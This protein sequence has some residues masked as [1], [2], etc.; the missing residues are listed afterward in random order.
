M[1]LLLVLL[2]VAAASKPQCDDTTCMTRAF[3]SCGTGASNSACRARVLADCRAA[4]GVA[5]ATLDPSTWRPQSHR[6]CSVADCSAKSFF[7]CGMDASF[8]ACRERYSRR[9]RRACLSKPPVEAAVAKVATC[10]KNAC[11]ARSFTQCGVGDANR[12]CRSTFVTN[13]MKGCKDGTT[14]PAKPVFLG[15]DHHDCTERSKVK[16][17]ESADAAMC[18]GQEYTACR[19]DSST[20]LPQSFVICGVGLQSSPCRHRFVEQCRQ[21][22]V[23][24]TQPPAPTTPAP[25]TAAT[26][27]APCNEEVCLQRALDFCGV[28]VHKHCNTEHFHY[29]MLD[30]PATNAPSTTV[31]DTVLPVTTSVAGATMV[32]CSAEAC[33]AAAVLVCSPAESAAACRKAEESKCILHC[34]DMGGSLP[35]ATPTVVLSPCERLKA[36]SARCRSRHCR[37]RVA[38]VLRNCGPATRRQCRQFRFRLRKCRFVKCRR[39]FTNLLVRRCMAPATTAPWSMN[40]FTDAPQPGANGPVVR[41]FNPFTAPTVAGAVVTAKPGS[42]AATTTTIAPCSHQACRLAATLV[43]GAANNKSRCRHREVARCIRHCS[44]PTTTTTTAA[45]TEAVTSTTTSASTTTT[46]TTTAPAVFFTSGKHGRPTRDPMFDFF[47]TTTLAPTPVPGKCDQNHQFELYRQCA[48]EQCRD[49][50]RAFMKS[51]EDENH[52]PLQQRQNELKLALRSCTDTACKVNVRGGL[53]KA[54]LSLATQQMKTDRLTYRREKKDLAALRKKLRRCKDEACKKRS[55]VALVEGLERIV[56]AKSRVD[57]LRVLRYA[58]RAEG[59]T[60]ANLKDF[61]TLREKRVEC[62]TK[63]CYGRIARKMQRA[64]WRLTASRAHFA[65]ESKLYK[66]SQRMIAL[67]QKQARVTVELAKCPS[68]HCRHDMKRLLRKF[69][70][71]ITRLNA[72][73]ER[74]AQKTHLDR[75]NAVKRVSARRFRK[76]RAKLIVKRAGCQTP[77]CVRAYT[78]RI[79]LYARIIDRVLRSRAAPHKPFVSAV[80]KVDLKVLGVKSSKRE[81]SDRDEEE[82]EELAS[83]LQA[84]KKIDPTV[85][86]VLAKESSYKAPACLGTLAKLHE[87]LSA[88]LKAGDAAKTKDIEAS[89]K[90]L[91]CDPLDGVGEGSDDEALPATKTTT[92]VATTVAT[93]QKPMS[94]LDQLAQLHEEYSK[95]L[96][97]SDRNKALELR[98]KMS[99]LPC[100]DESSETDDFTVSTTRS[101]TQAPGEANCIDQAALL[102]SE[103]AAALQSGNRMQ[104]QS[105]KRRMRFLR[106]SCRKGRRRACR[107]RA[108]AA[109]E[110]IAQLNLSLHSLFN[111]AAQCPS[112]SCRGRVER[113]IGST[114]RAL[115]RVRK[116][117]C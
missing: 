9:C 27:R 8:A 57:A 64:N 56:V 23:A 84:S 4:C 1:L 24:P 43:C 112:R 114:R 31:G 29:C 38:R 30:C 115:R 54:R 111:R 61:V 41:T 18:R 59:R 93:T 53:Q 28:G 32:P 103:Y 10:D 71:R 44:A 78:R 63:Q 12:P 83:Q 66:V 95:A 5:V 97:S 91:Q 107:A 16:C 58:L 109:E 73:L 102:H 21:E 11:F 88:A 36:A 81:R 79:D 14:A 76:L 34:N 49:G 48:T 96:G 55:S 35:T 13:C 70:R 45:T 6:G 82:M 94:C 15:C 26:T 86:K 65:K 3:Q 39:Q 50:V 46:T 7:V 100:N 101:N 116:P 75:H 2:A 87:S 98:K 42:T 52:G 89:I 74:K 67:V 47:R 33:R 85:A 17:G 110:R 37:R 77:G 62:V 69:T 99:A 117:T 25:T 90:E 19:A 20:C 80:A 104:A 92:T 40:P 72:R 22:C 108:N 68:R 60:I 105:V 51:C 113:M 106:L